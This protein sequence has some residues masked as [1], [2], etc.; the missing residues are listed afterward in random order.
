MIL[1]AMSKKP[2]DR[3]Q[4]AAEMERALASLLTTASAQVPAQTP[5]TPTPAPW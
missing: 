1:K 3:Y 4:D 2:A 5:A